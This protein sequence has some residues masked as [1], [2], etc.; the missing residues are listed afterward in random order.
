MC[1]CKTNDFPCIVSTQRKHDE[2]FDVRHIHHHRL[3][4]DPHFR[5]WAERISKMKNHYNNFKNNKKY[6]SIDIPHYKV[7][8]GHLVDRI[9]PET[10]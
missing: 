7:F 9:H 3:K 8:E 6:Q 2:P 4:R 10:I 5:E 1:T